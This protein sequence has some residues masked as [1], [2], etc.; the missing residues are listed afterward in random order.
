M[1][2]VLLNVAVSTT[3]IPYHIPAFSTF[4]TA[5]AHCR[6]VPITGETAVIHGLDNGGAIS[7]GWMGLT[8]NAIVL[9]TSVV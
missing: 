5:T 2:M 7:V 8:K 6:H 9:V 3:R 4:V 1:N